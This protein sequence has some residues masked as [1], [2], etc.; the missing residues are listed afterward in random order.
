VPDNGMPDTV[1]A[2]VIARA[3]AEYEAVSTAGLDESEVIRRYAPL[4]K[5]IA[6]HLKG[7]L[8]EAVQVDD[9]FQAGLIAV[10]RVM[11]R[12]GMSLGG[13]PP[14]SLHR[15]ITNAMIDEARRDTWAPVRTVR[16]AQNAGR[17]MR[18]VKQRLG[19][20]GTDEEIAEAM[21]IALAD[22]HQLLVEV[23]GIRLTPL[24][25]F[26]DANE[27]QAD[28][29]QH[30]DLDRS[31]MLSVLTEAVASLPERER[32]IVSLYYE[33]ELNMDEVGKVLGIDK[34]TVC[35]AH[36]RALLNLRVALGDWVTARHSISGERGD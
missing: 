6:T 22:Y 7:R 5:K 18:L 29:D 14:F 31:Q 15:I 26:E 11:R 13:M 19:R 21:G 4:V 10:L 28:D 1:E 9:L 8:P 23:A 20:D 32:T 2:P 17:A 12:D 36:G 35:R 25:R 27:P 16:L 24:E 34:S 30:A 3:A 33:H